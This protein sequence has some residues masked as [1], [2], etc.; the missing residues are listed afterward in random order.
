M[1]SFKDFQNST[2]AKTENSTPKDKLTFTSE[3][4]KN[5]KDSEVE[6]IELNNSDELLELIEKLKNR[7]SSPSKITPSYTSESFQSFM[8]EFSQACINLFESTPDVDARTF[9]LTTF[10]G[11]LTSLVVKYD[12]A[13]GHSKKSISELLKDSAEIVNSFDTHAETLNPSDAFIKTLQDLTLECQCESCKA[14]RQAA[15]ENSKL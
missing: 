11:A 9:I 1:A 3:L 6:V 8:S 5:L 7:K 10:A 2:A 15:K 4:L 13:D 14:K 12:L